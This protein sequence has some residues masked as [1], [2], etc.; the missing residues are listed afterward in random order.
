MADLT[1]EMTRLW[2]HSLGGWKR[3]YV[4]G[5]QRDLESA[6][7]DERRTAARLMMLE[8]AVDDLLAGVPVEECL[9]CGELL[10]CD[11]NDLGDGEILG[12]ES[13]C[14]IALLAEWRG[15]KEK[16]DA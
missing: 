14:P 9:V 8:R 1:S 11:E 10:P 7:E 13:G 15:Q 12:H 2:I 3:S 16:T 5:L 4:E 6:R